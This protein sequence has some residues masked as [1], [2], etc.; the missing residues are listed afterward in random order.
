MIAHVFLH[1]RE[2]ISESFTI[3][4]SRKQETYFRTKKKRKE[5]KRTENKS[6]FFFVNYSNSTRSFFLS[7]P[8]LLFMDRHSLMSQIQLF[9]ITYSSFTLYVHFIG[10]YWAIV[11][12]NGY[13]FPMDIFFQ[14]HI[15]RL[16]FSCN[17][18]HSSS[19]L[20]LTCFCDWAAKN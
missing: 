13:I 2:Y 14:L 16:Y 18:L 17:T 10:F 8:N 12:L 3:T 20:L 11:F 4:K 19:N 1:P 5:I 6:F 15:L 7:K 9:P